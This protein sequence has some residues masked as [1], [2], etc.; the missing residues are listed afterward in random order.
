MT[1]CMECDAVL[2]GDCDQ[3]G[4]TCLPCRREALRVIVVA[5]GLLT[6]EQANS[7]SGDWLDGIGGMGVEL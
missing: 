4:V 7:V 2:D 6:A 1:V 3:E 5:D